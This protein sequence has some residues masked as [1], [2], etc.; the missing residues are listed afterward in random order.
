MTNSFCQ[1][2]AAVQMEDKALTEHLHCLQQQSQCPRHCTNTRRCYTLKF[3]L[4]KE[5]RYRIK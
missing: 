1:S 2:E 5:D 3:F 4:K